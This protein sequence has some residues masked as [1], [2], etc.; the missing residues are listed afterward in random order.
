MAGASGCPGCYRDEAN[1][2]IQWIIKAQAFLHIQ[3]TLK[4][5]KLTY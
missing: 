1:R 2:E 5:E 3:C 4:T